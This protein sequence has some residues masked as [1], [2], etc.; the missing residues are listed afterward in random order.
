[1][2]F[3]HTLI[4]KID[5][6]TKYESQLLELQSLGKKT[7]KQATGLESER[8]ATMLSKEDSDMRNMAMIRLKTLVFKERIRVYEWMK[9]YDKLRVLSSPAVP[10]IF[11]HDQLFLCGVEF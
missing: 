2:T 4:P 5:E 7:T 3:I 6:E 8:F 11:I 9:D 1:M 10:R